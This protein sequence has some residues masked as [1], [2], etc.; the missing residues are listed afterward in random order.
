MVRAQVF[1][2]GTVDLTD[3]AA[4]TPGTCQV[5]LDTNTPSQ[6]RCLTAPG[7]LRG[8]HWIVTVSGQV[9]PPGAL[10]HYYAPVV[11]SVEVETV[12]ERMNVVP[13]EQPELGLFPTKGSTALL[14]GTH[15]GI[16]SNGQVVPGTVLHV[17]LHRRGDLNNVVVQQEQF[18]QTY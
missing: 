13:G 9:S 1:V 3:A 10:T 2:A 5:V 16:T 14:H 15:F 18:L 11:D 4:A 12:S 7:V 17:V 6:I 8:H